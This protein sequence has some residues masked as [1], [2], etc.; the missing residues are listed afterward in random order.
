MFTR[1]RTSAAEGG[2]S[3]GYVFNGVDSCQ[4]ASGGGIG[5]AVIQVTTA[6]LQEHALNPAVQASF[7]LTMKRTFGVCLQ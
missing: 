7:C 2:K 3:E 6:I 5:K 1:V 4:T